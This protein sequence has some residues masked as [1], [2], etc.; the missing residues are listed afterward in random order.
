MC[1]PQPDEFGITDSVEQQQNSLVGTA[2]NHVSNQTVKREHFNQGRTLKLKF[3]VDFEDEFEYRI[4]YTFKFKF[5]FKVV[6]T[7]LPKNRGYPKKKCGHSGDGNRGY[8]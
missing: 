6:V 5:K 4:Y 2:T 7:P 8:V 1:L 3:K